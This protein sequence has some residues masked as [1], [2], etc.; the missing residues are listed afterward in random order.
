MKLFKLLFVFLLV[1]AFGCENDSQ[2]NN[3]SDIDDLTDELIDE[4]IEEPTKQ[5]EE[6][7]VKFKLLGKWEAI[8]DPTL[9]IE[10]TSAK[11]RTFDQGDKVW[12]YEW[13]MTDGPDL[14]TA[15]KTDNGDHIWVYDDKGNIF[16]V[17]K[18]ISMSENEFTTLNIE[19]GWVG[20]ERSFSKLE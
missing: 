18:L 11:Y 9:T 14:T 17:D 8:D 7:S 2:S 3:D 5:V 15:F 6:N 12:D 16:Y 4:I 19:G 1:F 10:I 13:D 20:K